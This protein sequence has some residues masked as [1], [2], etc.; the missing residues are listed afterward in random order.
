MVWPAI[1]RLSLQDRNC[2]VSAVCSFVSVD[3]LGA[4]A[5]FLEQR[6]NA[7]PLMSRTGSRPMEGMFR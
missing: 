1:V 2:L 4:S 5:G 7:Y 6:A 3:A